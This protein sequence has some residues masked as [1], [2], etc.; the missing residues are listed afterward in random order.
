M[1]F[2]P[3]PQQAA[4]IDWV[5]NGTGNAI[6]V[7]VAG[8]GKT[9]TI[10]EMVR[11]I[12]GEETVAIV[13][14][15]KAI[16]DEIAGKVTTLGLDADVGTVH[17]FGMR[18]IR[19]ANR[20]VQVDNQKV[21]RIVEAGR[22]NPFLKDQ[23][24]ALV[25]KAK[26]AGVGVCTPDT[27]DTWFDLMDKYEI[28]VP[29]TDP[30]RLYEARRAL[31]E[32]AREVFEASA[33]DTKRID[34]DDMLYLPLRWNLDP[35]AYGFVFLDEAQDTNATRR[36]LVRR[37]VED[38]GRFCAVGDPAQAIYGFTGADTDAL[39]L[40][41][42]DFKT[43]ELPLT[44]TYRCPKAVVAV[45]RHWVSHI[46][47][48]ATAPAGKYDYIT[49]DMF[50]QGGVALNPSDAVLCRKTA[51]LVSLAYGLIRQGVACKVEGR[52]IGKGLVKLL[53]QWKGPKTI[54]TYLK[55]LDAWQAAE[56]RKLVEA[57]KEH[58]IEPLV[59]KCECVR[60]LAACFPQDEKLVKLIEMVERIFAGNDAKAGPMLTL[61]TI[62]R[63]KG[64]EWN[65]VFWIGR[66]AWQPSPYAKTPE[67]LQ[68]EMNLCYVAATR[69]KCE[70]IEVEA[71]PSG[72]TAQAA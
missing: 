63:S 35:E 71:P 56:E 16:A 51:P 15:N 43:I 4:A 34:F 58:L 9:T 66:E 61:A 30:E 47:A 59:D 57:K 23:L 55:K 64:R 2:R 48:H 6:L 3:S 53:Q 54:A 41:K 46:E 38:G 7:A 10:L 17:S 40:I 39:D 1:T 65:R 42:R 24:L 31:V 29:A 44:V 36:E 52:D 22:F 49:W 72:E 62:H 12:D 37:M 19:K 21:R 67:Q 13:A 28:E 60:E 68:Q 11:A 70:L 27:P 14:Y 32:Q 33:Q 18:A 26:L 45:A 20:S 25:S 69:A 50:R 5:A 8:A